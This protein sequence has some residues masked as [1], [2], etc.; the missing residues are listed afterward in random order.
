MASNCLTFS[1]VHTML[2]RESYERKVPVLPDSHVDHCVG[3]FDLPKDECNDHEGAEDEQNNN[4]GRFPPIWCIAAKA[5]Q[6]S[7]ML[8]I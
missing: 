1:E 2:L 7:V 8:A 4:V 6:V 3:V 5:T